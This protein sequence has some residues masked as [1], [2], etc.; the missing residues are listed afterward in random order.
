MVE[1]VVGVVARGRA[2]RLHGGDDEPLVYRRYSVRTCAALSKI[3]AISRAL[4]PSSEGFDP[5]DR[6]VSGRFGM[7]LRRV[8]EDGGAQIGDGVAFFVIDRDKLS[9]VHRKR[10][11]LG[12]N[13][14]NRLAEMHHAIRRERRAGRHD[15]LCA[16]AARPAAD[17]PRM[18]RHP[19]LPCR[20]A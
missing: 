2:A 11:L 20:R 18:S 14:R 16:V 3:A 8:R 19:R 5:V 1:S 15:E 9:G 4:V 6:H 7:K 10:E 12:D 13:Q 17:A